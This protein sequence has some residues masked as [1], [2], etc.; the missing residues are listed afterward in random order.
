V[1]VMLKD[2]PPSL[3]PGPT[4]AEQKQLWRQHPV[5]AW[6]SS[7]I[8]PYPPMLGVGR[9]VIGELSRGRGGHAYIGHSQYGKSTTTR[10]LQ[11]V[12]KEVFPHMQ[13]FVLELLKRTRPSL[14]S[15]LGQVIRAVD[16]NLPLRAQ[17]DDRLHQ[18]VRELLTLALPHPP[19]TVVILVDEG[20][21]MD[22]IEYE[23]LKYL[24]GQLQTHGVRTMVFVFGQPGLKD[25]IDKIKA[26]HSDHLIKRFFRSVYALHGTNNVFALKRIFQIFDA[27]THFPEGPKGWPF[28]QFYFPQA[29]ANNWR[30]TN[31]ARMAWTQIQGERSEVEIGTDV[32]RD[33]VQYYF[34]ELSQYDSPRWKGTPE[35]WQAALAAAD[36]ART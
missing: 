4:P 1:I 23:W 32:I 29:F 30:I 18:A 36:F 34:T 27:Q 2:A 7:L 11:R 35:L 31:E 12:I 5:M 21:N 13:V 3:R 20:Q 24:I 28:S 33:M 6:D 8:L 26:T 25:L 14:L 22:I 19:A 17:I 16:R 15:F 9:D 10:Y